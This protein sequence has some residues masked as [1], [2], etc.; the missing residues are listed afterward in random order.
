M[1]LTDVADLDTCEHAVVH[2]VTNEKLG[3]VLILAGPENPIRRKLIHERQRKLRKQAAGQKSGGVWKAVL[4]VD[5]EE[6]EE[7][8]LDF[9][10]ACTLGW[11]D[12][13]WTDGPLPFSAANARMVY[14]EKSWL[15]NQVKAVLEDSELFISSSPSA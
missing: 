4:S 11:S 8:V 15:R 9:L 12:L 5:P 1:K 6:E 7:L 2:P 10:V 3:A 13:E 14:T